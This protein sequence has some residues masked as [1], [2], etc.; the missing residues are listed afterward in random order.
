MMMSST[1]SL[2]L[3]RPTFRPRPVRLTSSIAPAPAAAPSPADAAVDGA[4]ASTRGGN[5]PY[6]KAALF[7]V[8][9]HTLCLVFGAG[10]W[11]ALQFL[12]DYVRPF[13]WACVIAIA[14]YDSQECLLQWWRQRLE[15]GNLLSVLFAPLSLVVEVAVVSI[16]EVSDAL[17]ALQHKLMRHHPHAR[18]P[19]GHASHGPDGTPVI[20]T[21][22]A[23]SKPA[24]AP[25]TKVSPYKGP[26]SYVRPHAAKGDSGLSP[27]ADSS[28]TARRM[29]FQRKLVSDASGKLVPP[30]T[31]T[32]TI[33]TTT[34]TPLTTIREHG[35]L[36]Q[37][38]TAT[39][40]TTGDLH[41]HGDGSSNHGGG[42]A[43]SAPYFKWLSRASVLYCAFQLSFRYLSSLLLFGTLYY[44]LWTLASRLFFRADKAE[45]KGE[46][47]APPGVIVKFGRM[48][49]RCCA[50]VDAAIRASILHNLR[51]YIAVASIVVAAL[52]VVLLSSLMVVQIGREAHSGVTFLHAAV[53]DA[54]FMEGN[55][56][57]LWFEESGLR[58]QINTTVLLV[59]EHAQTYVSDLVQQYNLTEFVD[60]LYNEFGGYLGLRP[61]G[62]IPSVVGDD[63]LLLDNA[64]SAMVLTGMRSPMAARVK[65]LHGSI[66]AMDL[67]SAIAAARGLLA[68]TLEQLGISPEELKA[69]AGEHIG[70]LTTVA[71]VMQTIAE[72]LLTN[73]A[74]IFTGFF[75][76]VGGAITHLLSASI[77]VLNLLLQTTV[78]L[79]LLFFLLSSETSPLSRLGNVLP[80]SRETRVGVEAALQKAPPVGAHHG[81][82]RHPA[83]GAADGHLR[84]GSSP[85]RSPAGVPGTPHPCAAHVAGVLRGAGGREHGHLQR[86]GPAPLHHRHQHPGWHE[87][88][89]ADGGGCPHGTSSD[90][91]LVSCQHA[92]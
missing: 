25:P 37:P 53:T 71:S 79:T 84:T 39:H 65:E 7:S 40:G 77:G 92:V 14:L 72:Q 3:K 89:E 45:A 47:S 21:D 22:A 74:A 50:G 66:L 70:T 76:W 34:T 9:A 8:I 30:R 58:D 59:E 42:G 6:I 81:T 62:T 46:P 24:A 16:K 33:T 31:T 56:V 11:Q 12:R 55:R 61:E 1:S 85:C 2:D 78:F 10:V 91:I 64:T 51:S 80:L 43:P 29:L 69:K 36:A 87:R 32:T 5:E 90:H 52:G 44:L 35:A 48:L 88:V 54:E 49:W 26:P 19:H 20:S 82:V 41:P 13:G 28:S 27:R 63:P 86:D 68:I 17:F 57:M 73:G 75:K 18:M 67:S 23:H 15:N 60:L 83:A 4:A 38:S